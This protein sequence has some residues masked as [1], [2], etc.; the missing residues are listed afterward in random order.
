M[1]NLT[2]SAVTL[3]GLIGAILGGAGGAAI[4]EVID[5]ALFAPDRALNIGISAAYGAMFAVVLAIL[6][7][8][9]IVLSSFTGAL[10]DDRDGI[11]LWMS[12][13][14]LLFGNMTAIAVLWEAIAATSSGH[15]RDM[16]VA[17]AGIVLISLGASF[18]QLWLPRLA[19]PR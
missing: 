2:L 5:V 15:G 9:V 11:A 1:R 18:G 16:F 12:R 7:S 10:R 4:V 17:A 3:L 14:S 8:A 13:L 19:L 6:S